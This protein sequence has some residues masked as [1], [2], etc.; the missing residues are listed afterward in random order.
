MKMNVYNVCGWVCVCLCVR[1]YGSECVCVFRHLS[2]CVFLNLWFETSPM[3]VLFAKINFRKIFFLS[4]SKII[5]NKICGFG[6]NSIFTLNI[7]TLFTRKNELYTTIYKWQDKEP[8]SLSIRVNQS[9]NY[10]IYLF[11]FIFCLCRI[12]SDCLLCEIIKNDK[13]ELETPKIILIS[14]VDSDQRH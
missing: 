7:I 10:H 1:V 9:I 4:L 8:P 3:K 12:S 13:S 11:F 5:F 2:L 6:R 14:I